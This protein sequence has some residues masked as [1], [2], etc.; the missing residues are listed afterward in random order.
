MLIKEVEIFSDKATEVAMFYENIGAEVLKKEDRYHIEVGASKLLIAP[1][2]ESWTYHLAYNIPFDQ[3]EAARDWLSYYTEVQSFQGEEIV[4][5]PKWDARAIYFYDPAGNILEL[6]GRKPF[7]EKGE[8]TFNFQSLINISEVGWPADDVQKAVQELEIPLYSQF[9]PT[10]SAIGDEEGLL[11]IVD[12]QEKKW[13][14]NDDEIQFSPATLKIRLNER[15]IIVR[16]S[17]GQK[18]F[19]A[20][21]K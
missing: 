3:V 5:F 10:F 11:I 4:N 2:G 7:Q 9:G 13:M 17:A 18:E 8:G 20:E 15:N 1:S 16:R 6:I 19:E 14:P 12:A 21:Y